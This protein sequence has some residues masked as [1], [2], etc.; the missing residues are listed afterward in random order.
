M[1]LGV[2]KT[3]KRRKCLPLCISASE[4]RRLTNTH[5][6]THTRPDASDQ[7][8]KRTHHCSPLSPPTQ[9]PRSE[10]V[11]RYAGATENIHTHTGTRV[12]GVSECD[13]V[14]GCT[15]RT[16]RRLQCGHMTRVRV[17]ECGMY[18]KIHAGACVY[19]NEG[20]TNEGKPYTPPSKRCGYRTR[21]FYE[22]LG[23]RRRSTHTQ[24]HPSLYY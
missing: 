22:A 11:C 15:Q 2:A 19:V 18:M 5:V 6:H 9:S 4:H 1:K 24:N 23:E 17:P 8:D 14:R 12:C 10:S 21:L 20:E 16:Q 3:A 13:S 7:T